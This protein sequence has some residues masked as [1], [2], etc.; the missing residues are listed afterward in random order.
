MTRSC[1][2]T[3]ASTGTTRR[4]RRL[5]TRGRP[6]SIWRGSIGTERGP[7]GSD[8]YQGV[9]TTTPSERLAAPHSRS[10]EM[11]K[12]TSLERPRRRVRGGRRQRRA[13][14]TAPI[15]SAKQ[16]RAPRQLPFRAGGAARASLRCRGSARGAPRRLDRRVARI[17]A[18]GRAKG[19]QAFVDGLAARCALRSERARFAKLPACS[20]YTRA[21]SAP[22]SR[23]ALTR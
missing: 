22:K 19:N 16:R 14:G 15:G 11:P 7:S 4:R 6:S 3:G 18:T 5:G 9:R 17:A 12:S 23:N 8:M 20:E 2:S 10:C 21:N 1:A 13:R